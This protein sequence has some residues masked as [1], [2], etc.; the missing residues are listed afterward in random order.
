MG[1]GLHHH[2]HKVGILKGVEELDHVGM[3]HVSVNEDLAHDLF[4]ERKKFEAD[5]RRFDNLHISLASR[6]FKVVRLAL[7]YRVKLN[8]FC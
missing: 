6:W 4:P 3:A 7:N 8:P 2:V 5:E 1:A